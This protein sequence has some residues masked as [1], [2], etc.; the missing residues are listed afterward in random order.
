MHAQQRET[1]TSERRKKLVSKNGMRKRN[2]GFMFCCLAIVF[3][4][5]GDET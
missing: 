3:V 1:R 4:G 2:T 5:F